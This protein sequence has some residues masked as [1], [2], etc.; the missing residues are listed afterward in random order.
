MTAVAHFVA[1][2]EALDRRVTARALI[3]ELRQRR[4]ALGLKQYIFADEVGIAQPRL[5]D[6]ETGSRPGEQ[7]QM[8]TFL[9]WVEALD[10]RVTVVWE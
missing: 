10:G 3:A 2:R 6:Y 9:R 1:N 7:M 4:I 8:R 5:S